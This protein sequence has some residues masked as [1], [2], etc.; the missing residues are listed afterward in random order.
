MEAAGCTGEG[1][2]NAMILGFGPMFCGQQ[3]DDG[4]V[5][6][7]TVTWSVRKHRLHF[8]IIRVLICLFPFIRQLP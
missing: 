2:P 1:K 7:P 8:S 4:I 5:Y 3:T 6:V